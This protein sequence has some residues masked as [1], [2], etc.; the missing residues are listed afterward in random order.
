MPDSVPLIFH[1]EGLQYSCLSLSLDAVLGHLAGLKNLEVLGVEHMSHRIRLSEVQW[2]VKH[3][4]KLRRIDGLAMN[5]D[6]QCTVPPKTEEA[7]Q[8]LR[9]HYPGTELRP[10]SDNM[11]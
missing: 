1:D 9:D 4:P 3:W 11:R 5:R 10:T 8:W 2:M 6:E 7:A